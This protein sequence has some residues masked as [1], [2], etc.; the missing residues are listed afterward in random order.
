MLNKFPANLDI[1]DI[2]FEDNINTFS[3]SRIKQSIIQLINLN[4]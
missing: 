1:D 3:K 4:E 2:S